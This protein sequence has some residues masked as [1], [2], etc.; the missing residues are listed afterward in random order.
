M[1]VDCADA[2]VGMHLELVQRIRVLGGFSDCLSKI[3]G[4]DVTP[5]NPSCS[6]SRRNLPLSVR[7]RQ[8]VEPTRLTA[9]FELL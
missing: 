7:L 4:F 1:L 5:F 9:S 8:I 3:E 6:R 2:V